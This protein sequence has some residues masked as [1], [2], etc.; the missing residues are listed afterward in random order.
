MEIGDIVWRKDFG[1][2]R[3]VEIKSSSLTPYLVYFYKENKCLHNGNGRGPD[4]H[5]WLCCTGTLTPT[6]PTLGV[7]V[8][9][10]RQ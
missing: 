8:E 5:Y 1:V 9:R 4:N 10:R 7:L 2:G 6:H 3:I